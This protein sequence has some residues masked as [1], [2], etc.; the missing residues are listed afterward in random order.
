MKE[1]RFWRAAAAFRVTRYSSSSSFTLQLKLMA[2][3]A[4]RIRLRELRC[5]LLALS[6]LRHVDEFE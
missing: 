6:T 1:M 3:D 2:L 4:A 5:R